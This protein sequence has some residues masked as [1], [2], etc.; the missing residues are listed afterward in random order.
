MS[1]E[2]VKFTARV[3]WYSIAVYEVETRKWGV[4][5]SKLLEWTATVASLVNRDSFN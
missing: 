1:G 4:D 5:A 2:V 3:V